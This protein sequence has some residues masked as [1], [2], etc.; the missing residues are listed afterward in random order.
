MPKW[1]TSTW[2][3]VDYG[4]EYESK[5]GVLAA[6]TENFVTPEEVLRLK[7]NKLTD[8]LDARQYTA[9]H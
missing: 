2:Y 6:K 8:A 5:G 4:W 7:L 1:I 3:S 9:Y